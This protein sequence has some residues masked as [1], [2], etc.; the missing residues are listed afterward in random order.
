MTTTNTATPG[1]V[2]PSSWCALLTSS[3]QQ[4]V[5][6]RIE[7]TRPHGASRELLRSLRRVGT[8]R[9]R[10]R[11]RLDPPPILSTTL[12]S[13][14]DL[15]ALTLLADREPY[16]QTVRPSGRLSAGSN[17]SDVW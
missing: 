9:C 12:Y 11:L 15:P 10:E 14:A 17:F 1:C 16:R 6:Y 5:R 4:P 13:L 7:S 8:F 2:L 3:S